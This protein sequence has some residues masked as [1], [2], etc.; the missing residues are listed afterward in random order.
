M[1][2]LANDSTPFHTFGILFDTS[3]RDTAHVYISLLVVIILFKY[4]Y[5]PK[6]AAHFN[7]NLVE[8]FKLHSTNLH[9]PK[10]WF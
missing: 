3:A 8:F 5:I 4:V 1:N 2:L 7:I 6:Q 9:K 10:N